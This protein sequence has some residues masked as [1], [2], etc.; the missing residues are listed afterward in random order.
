MQIVFELDATRIFM[1]NRA[2][3]Q[4]GTAFWATPHSAARG[5][6]W[7]SWPLTRAALRCHRLAR[8]RQDNGHEHGPWPEPGPGPGPESRLAV[9]SYISASNS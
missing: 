3:C 1:Q 4:K 9:S 8:H 7:L 5:K 2:V 6:T